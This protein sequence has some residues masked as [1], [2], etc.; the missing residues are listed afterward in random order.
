MDNKIFCIVQSTNNREDH[1]VRNQE[2][3]D[4]ESAAAKH[5]NSRTAIDA[6]REL[7]VKIAM[8]TN[9]EPF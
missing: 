2:N 4:L 1:A 9:R 3:S 7:S 8:P 6:V 5:T